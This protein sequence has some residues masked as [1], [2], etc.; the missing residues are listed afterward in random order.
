MR[1]ENKRFPGLFYQKVS[2]RLG[3]VPSTTGHP[4]LTDW[5]GGF[6]EVVAATW[7]GAR[8]RC[9][10]LRVF[11]RF[12]QRQV[13]V[14]ILPFR[15]PK[16]N[17]ACSDEQKK[18]FKQLAKIKSYVARIE[19]TLAELAKSAEQACASDAA[20]SG[21]KSAEDVSSYYHFDSSG[22]KL[23]NKWDSFDVDAECDK[24]DSAPAAQARRPAPSSATSAILKQLHGVEGE[25][26]AV[27]AYIDRVQSAGDETVK[28]TRKQ[29]V[30]RVTDTL[31]P[32][33]DKL[34][35][36]CAPRS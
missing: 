27:C 36:Q 19:T 3:R 21:G 34:K 16:L 14:S 2:G 32:L 23:K 28:A 7:F 30:V 31:L 5:H 1:I 20:S 12:R 6:F 29:L 9:R 10:S 11:L 15:L 33:V 22:K 18:K 24:V 8:C 25:L 4:Q 26:E 35:K 17:V 13:G